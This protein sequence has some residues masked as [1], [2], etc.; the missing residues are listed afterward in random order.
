MSDSYYS[1]NQRNT[2][3]KEKKEEDLFTASKVF[4]GD[5]EDKKVGMFSHH[6]KLIP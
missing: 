5:V 2:Q 4:F 3:P 1:T 6:L